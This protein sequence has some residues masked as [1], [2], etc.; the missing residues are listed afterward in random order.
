MLALVRL[1]Y[2]GT[3]V[4]RTACLGLSYKIAI[5][6]WTKHVFVQLFLTPF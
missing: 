2:E 6:G 1:R 5:I 3:T 4:E